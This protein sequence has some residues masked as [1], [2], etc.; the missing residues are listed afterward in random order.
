MSEFM[1]PFDQLCKRLYRFPPTNKNPVSNTFCDVDGQF[2]VEGQMWTSVIQYMLYKK[3][4]YD[5]NIMKQILAIH[6]VGQLIATFGGEVPCQSE[7][8]LFRDSVLKRAIYAKFE[9]NIKLY[10]MLVNLSDSAISSIPDDVSY[11]NKNYKI[12]I[13]MARLLIEVRDYFKKNGHPLVDTRSGEYRPKVKEIMKKYA[14]GIKIKKG[15]L[16]SSSD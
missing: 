14:D 9:Q 8:L 1:T 13:D 4:M 6:D 5:P 12:E 2:I 3:Y 7:W 15:Q 11:N 10:Y 16:S